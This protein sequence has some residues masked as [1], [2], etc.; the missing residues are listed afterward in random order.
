[1]YQLK[2]GKN[3]KTK[4]ISKQIV[5]KSVSTVSVIF[6][7][8]AVVTILMI[9]SMT[10]SSNQTEL[11]LQSQAVS[12]QLA[13]YFNQYTR[14]TDQMALDHDFEELLE[15]NVK[16]DD[17]TKAERYAEVLH[18]MENIAD[19]DENIMA[20]WVGDIDA[21]VL[22]QSDG[23]TSPDGWDITERPWYAVIETK[24]NM[25]TDPYIDASTGDLI[26]SAA[27]PVI[28]D[29]GKIVGVSGLDI[30]MKQI[31]QIVSE[32]TIGDEGFVM[33]CSEDGT[34]IYHPNEELIQQN[35]T[36]IDFSDNLVEAL[37]SGKN[38]FL[39]YKALGVTK[40][41]YVTQ[42]DETGFIVVSNIP[43]DEYFEDLV[44]ML[45]LLIVIFA[46]G[47]LFIVFAMRQVSIKLAKPIMELNDTAQ[48]L[49][50]GDL[51][52]TID[53]K[54]E[55]EIGQ[56]GNS[57]SETVHRLKEYIN[58]IDEISEVLDR[59]ASGKLKIELKYAYVGEFQKV[60]VALNNISDTMR[61]VMQG[62]NESSAQVSAGSDDLA[63][64]SQGLAE[65][66]QTLAAAIEELVATATTVSE[67]VDENKTEAENS[68]G[69]TKEVT[70]MMVVSEQRMEEMLGAMQKIQ[71]TSRQVVGIIQTIEDIASQTNLL[72]LNASIE[73]ARAG[74]A[75]RGFAVV[76]G[77]IGSLADESANAV[78]TTRDLIGV[79]L[80]EIDR[81]TKIAK[82]V[83]ESISSSVE[84]IENVNGMIQK[85]AQ[86]A[87]EQAQNMEQIL[88]GVEDMSMSIQDTS[89][90]AEES[91][92]TSEE[93]AAQAVTLNDLVNRFELN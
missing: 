7:I 13:D 83:E 15:E 28:S 60:K 19:S 56:L 73:A 44:F 41:G 5:A 31:T 53:V 50:A 14:V 2:K 26:L 72:A 37:Q 36:E 92:A 55:D 4:S 16:G 48:K 35:I 86:N 65:S 1:M 10:M 3:S 11:T 93:L 45:V 23:Y 67:Q 29:E 42:V 57:I 84:A 69:K 20:A 87:V 62:I 32:H 40:Y 66:S 38:E 85:T 9:W 77:E 25:L 24:S 6:V 76:A 70:N 59:I 30:S 71:E 58:Y 88:K 46:A 18:N 39:K 12:Y 68:A 22:T 47:I 64:A 75:G 63:N 21:S 49:A 74:E 27:S 51:D 17:I 91:S 78:N 34:I 80:S 90:M 81:G 79:S 82:E 43:S 52:V 33:L 8:V 89:A 61:E 54:T